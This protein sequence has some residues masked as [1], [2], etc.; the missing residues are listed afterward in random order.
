MSRRTSSP[1]GRIPGRQFHVC[2]YAGAVVCFLWLAGAALASPV[3]FI[4][5]DSHLATTSAP[6]PNSAAATAAFTAAVAGLGDS[7][8]INGLEALPL[9]TPTNGAP[10]DLGLGMGVT[11]ANASSF[12]DSSGNTQYVG[13]RYSHH[14]EPDYGGEPGLWLQYDE[15]RIAVLPDRDTDGDSRPGDADHGHV[16]LRI[17]DQRLRP[18]GDGT[19]ERRW[20]QR[21]AAIR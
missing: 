14:A 11:L 2:V 5:I 8:L 20:K 17:A 1:H 18:L 10:L 21:D 3:T 19:W 13:Q 6:R 16:R 9:T 7:V 15:R 4:G 12:T